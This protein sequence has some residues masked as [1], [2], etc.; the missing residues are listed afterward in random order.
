MSDRDYINGRLFLHYFETAP[1]EE[2][3]LAQEI[4]YQTKKEVNNYQAWVN[5][6]KIKNFKVEDYSLKELYR[7]VF[8]RL[9]TVKVLYP[10]MKGVNELIEII[11]GKIRLLAAKN[12]EV[13]K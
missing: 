11:H 13:K 12:L 6:K 5:S 10:E 7:A 2:I 8:L 1:K 9:K 4:I 3:D